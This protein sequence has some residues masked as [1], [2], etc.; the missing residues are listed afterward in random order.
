MS[1]YPDAQLIKDSQDLLVDFDYNPEGSDSSKKAAFKLALQVPFLLDLV[2]RQQKAIGA[3]TIESGREIDVVETTVRIIRARV[4]KQAFEEALEIIWD[5]YQ[6]CEDDD[7][8]L[9]C[10]NLIGKIRALAKEG[11]DDEVDHE[12]A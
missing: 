9:A 4:R 8:L 11:G 10:E 5:L 6:T 3:L 7:S 2:E 1:N 12:Q